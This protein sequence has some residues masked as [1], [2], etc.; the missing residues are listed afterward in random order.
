MTTDT[1]TTFF[2]LLAV[3]ALVVVVMVC[4]VAGYCSVSG[5]TPRWVRAVQVGVAPLALPMA[6]A[7]ATTCTLGSL[8]LSEVARFP[9]CELCWYQRIAMYPL[10]VL[11]GVGA[12]RRDASVRW[13]AVPLAVIGLGV[14]VYHYFVERFPDSIATSCSNDVP[15]STVWVWKFHF[16]SI[17]AM[18]GAGF[19]LII[20]LVLL[21]RS[22]SGDA[23]T[24]RPAPDDSH[25]D[26][27]PSQEPKV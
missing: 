1:M 4:A 15:C 25:H 14:S 20:V 2:A 16:L 5:Q 13:Y 26:R 19:A 18:A 21:A 27:D 11:L 8:Y 17:P 10:V 24:D 7:V 23:G 3:A 9:P 6:W 12:L 22:S